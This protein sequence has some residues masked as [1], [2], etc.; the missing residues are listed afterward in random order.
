MT[1]PSPADA[2]AG[3][4]AGLV[5]A[6]RLVLMG[7]IAA[8]ASHDLNNLLGKIIGLAELTMDEIADRPGACAE[9]RERPEYRRATPFR[10]RRPG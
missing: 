2:L 7:R 8:G 4:N 5:E 6:R 3:A 10:S 1:A 9:A